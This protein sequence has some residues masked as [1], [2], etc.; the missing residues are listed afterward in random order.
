MFVDPS[1]RG[2]DETSWAC[3]KHLMGN[4]YLTKVGA[5]KDGYAEMTLDRILKD[6]SAQNVKL[7]L[8]EPN[9][10][11]GMFA[12]F[13]RSRSRL[14]YPV[15]IEDSEWSKAQK[16]ARIIDVLEPLMNHHRLVVDSKVI[17]WDY[18]HSAL[19][20][21]GRQQVPAVLPDDPHHAGE[22]SPGSG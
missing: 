12:Q 8:V 13:L 21:R 4:L 17:E 19:P 15:N 5:S 11:D 3:M 1:G 10:G 14:Q 20:L 2:K 9:M 18:E 7:I 16:E 22:G 6:A